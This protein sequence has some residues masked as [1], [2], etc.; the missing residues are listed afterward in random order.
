MS[1]QPQP[2]PDRIPLTRESIGSGEIRQLI[3]SHGLDFHLLSDEELAASRASMFGD[4]GITEDVW[5]FGYGSL[6]WNPTI[7]YVEKRP[8]TV[9]GYHRKFCLKAHLGRGTPD[10]PGLVLGLD[11]GGCCRGLAFR[12]RREIADEELGLVWRREMVTDSYRPTWLTGHAPEGA[13]KVIGFV[14]DR[15]TDRY[16]G[17]MCEDEAADIIA[18]A[19]G[20]LG[21]CSEYLF[22]T[23]D[24]LRTLGIP[25]AGLER[26]RRKVVA[27][28]SAADGA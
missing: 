12:I 22:N 7:H 28:Q 10:A 5:L 25:D 15:A 8:V 14:M 27:R 11:R 18:K 19:E 1:D 16:C 17:D 21:P 13:I 4:A 3:R 26:L 23:I 6:I 9:Y 20:F 24:H 2:A